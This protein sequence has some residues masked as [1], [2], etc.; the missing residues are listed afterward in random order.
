MYWMWDRNLIQRWQYSRRR[1]INISRV[2][3]LFQVASRHNHLSPIQWG[4]PWY[5]EEYHIH[6]NWGSINSKSKSGNNKFQKAIYS[7]KIQMICPLDFRDEV[8]LNIIL[9]ISINIKCKNWNL[10]LNATLKYFVKG[11][12]L[13]S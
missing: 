8:R 11:V 10:L 5:M 6:P 7:F 3:S 2:E 1:G 4:L 9:N 12:K 13:V